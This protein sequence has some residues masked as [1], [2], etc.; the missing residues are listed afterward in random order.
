MEDRSH[1]LREPDKD[2]SLNPNTRKVERFP[3]RKLY[4]MMLGL[5]KVIPMLLAL[6]TILGTMFDF[7]GWDA[8]LFSFVGGISFLP[9]LFLYLSSYVFRFCV[10]H[11]MFLHYIVANNILTYTDYLFGI[12]IST[13]S[14]FSIHLVL[15]GIFLFLVLYFYRREK[16]CRQSRNSCLASSMT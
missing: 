11:R 10:Y 14:L 16:C 2:Q 6:S 12:P 9:L 7:F 15:I 1:P 5:L 8:S 4:K 13:I 3:E